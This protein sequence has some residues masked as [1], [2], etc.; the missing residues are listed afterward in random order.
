MIRTALMVAGICL[1]I[2]LGLMLDQR[3][4]PKVIRTTPVALSKTQI[5]APGRVEGA[6][7]QTELRFRVTERVAEVLVAE[8]QLVE[9]GD[10]LVRLDDQQYRHE[11]ALAAAQLELAEAERDRLV[12]GA[13]DQERQEARALYEAK[14]TELELA[15]TSWNRIRALVT[16]NAV[17]QQKA[18]DEKS[19]VEALTREAEAAKARLDLLEA[20]PRDDEL[21]MA[22]AKIAAAKARL[23]LARVPL[24]QTVLRAPISGQVLAV[25]VEAG[26]LTGPEAR[27][28]AVVLAEISRFRVR[29]F[30]EELDAPRVAVGMPAVVMADGLPGKKFMGHVAW[31]SPR[32]T[33]KSL[34][35][36]DPQERFDT[37]TREI[38]I[39]LDDADG[40]VLGLRVDVA[41]DPAQA[42]RQSPKI[43]DGQ[44]TPS[45]DNND[46]P[47]FTN[48]SG[49][50]DT[51]HKDQEGARPL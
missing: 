26:E 33:P 48:A 39:D 18:D 31:L 41:I 30:V 28:P 37:K 43:A 46:R 34:W 12:R 44:S 38:W 27:E 45:E 40:L 42:D 2:A 29:A 35:T 51:E 32:M 11:V 13:R 9:A 10:V 3:S 16:Q 5:F 8:G 36:D 49:A 15:K 47:V 19:R 20:P 22:D 17:S 6:S 7:E 21:K 50:D 24:E 4:K 23:E 14:L 25:N 1:I